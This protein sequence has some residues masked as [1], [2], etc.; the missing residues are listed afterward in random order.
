MPE[1]PII[2]QDT[3]K[4][5]IYCDK[6]HACLEGSFIMSPENKAIDI[7]VDCNHQCQPISMPKRIKKD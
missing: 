2:L 3:V 7:T 5:K 4:I 6:C 1:L